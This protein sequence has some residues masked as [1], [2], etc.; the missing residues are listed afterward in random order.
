MTTIHLPAGTTH[1]KFGEIPK[2]ITDVLNPNDG[3][4][5]SAIRYVAAC[6]E[7][8]RALRRAVD[9][10]D[11]SVMSPFNPMVPH[12]FPF[13]EALNRALVPVADL[14]QFVSSA[15][16]TVIVDAPDKDTA[17]TA[18][19]VTARDDPSPVKPS[20]HSTRTR[21]DT[22]T[23]VI[24]QAQ[25]KCRNPKD[26]AEVWAQMEVLAEDEVPPFQGRMV[27]GLKYTKKDEVKYFTRSA[28]DKRL[29]PEKRTT[30]GKRR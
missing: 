11:L 3:T 1:V 16:I 27:E 6:N 2:L 13:G 10:G 22:I 12:E 21:R 23:P 29:H 5:L 26:T 25:S 4:D 17:M 20:I 8:E 9:A 18:T 19:V 30:P 7:L 15:G 14:R 28:L 24:D